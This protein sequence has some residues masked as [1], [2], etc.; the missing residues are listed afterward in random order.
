MSCFTGRR[1]RLRRQRDGRL[2]QSVVNM[3]E[4]GEKERR[5]EVGNDRKGPHVRERKTKLDGNVSSANHGLRE[6][7]CKSQ[8]KIV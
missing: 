7:S 5:Q 2:K 1:W 8:Q 6:N 4:K 3:V